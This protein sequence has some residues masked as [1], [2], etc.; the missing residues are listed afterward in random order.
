MNTLESSKTTHDFIVYA[1]GVVGD[2]NPW[3]THQKRFFVVLFWHI[4]MW[5]TC[6]RN[7]EWHCISRQLGKYPTCNS[8]MHIG[9]PDFNFVSSTNNFNHFFPLTRAQTI[10]LDLHACVM[11][12]K[13]GTD[14]FIWTLD[15][16]CHRRSRI[17]A[18]VTDFAMHFF[19]FIKFTFS[20]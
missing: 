13:R 8:D 16:I 12:S 2:K 9:I 10:K 5:N 17:V 4:V 3:V 19:F 20:T 15:N 14:E 11:E 1:V 18:A 7:S 6:S